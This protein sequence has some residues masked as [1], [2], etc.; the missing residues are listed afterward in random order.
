[1]LA[2]TR[3]RKGGIPGRAD[4]G[5]AMHVELD[6]WKIKAALIGL[7]LLVV[8]VPFA[9]ASHANRSRADD[10]RKRA[11]VAEES[12][13]GLRVVIVER[14]RALNQRTRQANELATAARS[15]GDALRRSKASVGTLTTRQRALAKENASIAKEARALR[16]QLSSLEAI[17]AKLDA[18]AVTAGAAPRKAASAPAKARVAQ[19]K[20][21]AASYDAYRK[22]S[23]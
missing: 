12:V 23:R 11:L 7:A 2:G 18:C 3:Y 9:R 6:G 1:M 8:A 10:W 20:R 16:T 17:A 15:R 19:C 21:V 5:R 4:V 22:Q 14:S 13:A